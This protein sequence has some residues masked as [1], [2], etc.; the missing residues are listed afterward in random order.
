MHS[1]R[2]LSTNRTPL[3]AW[4]EPEVW[5]TDLGYY[6]QEGIVVPPSALSVGPHT[7][8]VTMDAPDGL[9]QDQIT[10]YIDAPGTGSCS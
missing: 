6:V 5:G 8:S 3:K 1:E 7:L 10:F 4:L 9:F 2:T